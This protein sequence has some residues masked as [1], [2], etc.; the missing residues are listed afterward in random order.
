MNY[1]A[2]ASGEYNQKRCIPIRVNT[3]AGS[4]K[5][6][7]TY[8]GRYQIEFR[9]YSELTHS[10]LTAGNS[11]IKTLPTSNKAPLKPLM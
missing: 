3:C 7:I 1:P 11:E 5:P 10:Y 4:L 8:L 6:D 9:L 2:Q